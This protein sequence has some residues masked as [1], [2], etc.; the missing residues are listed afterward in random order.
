MRKAQLLVF[1]REAV[2]VNLVLRFQLY[3]LLDLIL[4]E[5]LGQD[6]NRTE[7]TIQAHDK[8]QGLDAVYLLLFHRFNLCRSPTRDTERP[9]LIAGRT[10]E[11]NRSD[12]KK[13]CPSVI[14]ITFVGI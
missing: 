8:M 5:L 12:C 13:I 4:L 10:P 11:K 2:C 7:Q 3:A 9:A 6:Q 14:E 1:L